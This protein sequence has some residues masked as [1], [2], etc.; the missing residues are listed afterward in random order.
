MINTLKLSSDFRR[1]FLREVLV[2]LVAILLL[3]FVGAGAALFVGTSLTNTEAR[4]QQQR[5]IEASFSQSLNEH[6]RQLH[7]LSRWG[8]LSSI[9]RR[10][11]AAGG[12]MRTLGCGCMRCSAIS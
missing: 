9:W 7:S 5:M 12:W 4:H 3:T 6:L 11:T 10:A 2:P 1:S 8:P